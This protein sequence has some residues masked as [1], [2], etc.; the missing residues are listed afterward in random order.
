MTHLPVAVAEG[1]FERGI[2]V[3]AVEMNQAE[4]CSTANVGPVVERSHQD[5]SPDAQGAEGGDGGLTAEMI[6]VVEGG[7]LEDVDDRRVGA[8]E[9][10]EGEIARFHGFVWRAGVVRVDVGLSDGDESLDDGRVGRD[11]ASGQFDASTL[12]GLVRV[13]ERRRQSVGVEHAGPVG[14]A[15]RQLPVDGIGAVQM[16]ADRRSVMAMTGDDNVAL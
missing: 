10:T 3:G 1:S 12:D 11:P 2:D 9:L 6:V 13:V 7:S 15:E 5:G 8:G 16:V 14:S 4:N